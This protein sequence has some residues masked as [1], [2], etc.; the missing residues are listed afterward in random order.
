M[1]ESMVMALTISV[2]RHKPPFLAG[3]VFPAGVAT[4]EDDIVEPRAY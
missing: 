1:R 4:G 3:G 2:D